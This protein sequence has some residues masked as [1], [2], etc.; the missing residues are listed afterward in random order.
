VVVL[1]TA[2]A[3][4]LWSPGQGVERLTGRNFMELANLGQQ[5]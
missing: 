3:R 1:G 5:P 2:M 4:N